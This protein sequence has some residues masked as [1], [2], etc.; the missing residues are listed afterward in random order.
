MYSWYR[1]TT[2]G[3]RRAFVATFGG[4]ALEA[5]DAQIFG[6]VLPTL[7]ALWHLS[8][9]QAGLLASATL[10]C[11]ALGGWLAGFASDRWGRVRVLQVTIAWYA[12][13]TALVGF[14]GG[15]ESL[16]VL[17]CLQGF[18]FGGEWA[19]GAVLISEYVSTRYRGRVLGAV[20]SG[21]AV[22]WGVA[23][24]AFSAAFSLLPA[25]WA[26]RVM[27][28]LGVLPALLVVLI[29]RGVGDPPVYR[30]EREPVSWTGIFRPGL[31]RVTIFGALLGLGSHGG[32]YALTTFLRKTR[33]LTVL[34]TTGY[35]AVFITAA[36]AG[37]VVSGIMSDRVGR[38]KNIIG[39][40]VL[41]LLSL[42]PFL[43]LPL[44]NA[45]MLVAS[46]P[47]GFFSAG[48]P[49]GLGALFAELFPTEVRGSGQGFCYNLGRIVSA[50]FPA[51][52]GFL[53]AEIGLAA[54]IAVFAG[55]AYLLAIVAACCLPE[56]RTAGLPDLADPST[57][58][59]HTV[60]R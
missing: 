37:Y 49:G 54:S 32:Y 58:A 51:A 43:L 48:M 56:T 11:T 35:L 16:L 21:W 57:A 23:L 36:F 52:V 7:M 41:C 38:R 34:S 22:G 19:A 26:W 2:P 20:Q 27:F 47:L 17:R 45:G 3:G 28:W 44:N 42:V 29:R 50:A 14:A 55:A 59:P 12:V 5:A 4:W 33:G 31:A 18:G 60:S 1:S 40:A 6:L 53:S 15:F 25:T 39:F 13:A 8:E 30:R 10:V 46:A 24:V 9:G